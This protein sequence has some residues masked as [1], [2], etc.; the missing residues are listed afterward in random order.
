MP[1]DNP[2]VDVP[3]TDERLIWCPGCSREVAGVCH[4]HN[5]A[6]GP[7]GLQAQIDGQKRHPDLDDSN[8]KMVDV[9]EWFDRSMVPERLPEPHPTRNLPFGRDVDTLVLCKNYDQLDLAVKALGLKARYDVWSGT[10]LGSRFNKIIWIAG[11]GESETESAV[12]EAVMR[13]VLP[14]KLH[15]DGKLFVL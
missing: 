13:E 12:M 5:C 10:L 4:L 3:D 15:L 9:K 1:A 14:T 7:H 6:I 11:R 8:T 2:T